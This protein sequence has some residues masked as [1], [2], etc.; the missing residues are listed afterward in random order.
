MI[1]IYN[2]IGSKGEDLKSLMKNADD[3]EVDS[4]NYESLFIGEVALSED[5]Q[6][7]LYHY[8]S[9]TVLVVGNSERSRLSVAVSTDDI[10]MIKEGLAKKLG[11]TL[12]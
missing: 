8:L 10:K 12:I 2:W 6:A 5:I 9:S 4:G 7:Q 1:A 3:Q 11:A